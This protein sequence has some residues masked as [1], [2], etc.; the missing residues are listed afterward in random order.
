MRKERSLAVTIFRLVSVLPAQL[1][2]VYLTVVS[3]ISLVYP[4]P[5]SI[6]WLSHR[7]FKTV[8]MIWKLDR[9]LPIRTLFT[10]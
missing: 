4:L 7:I 6:A 9:S 3:I 10:S 1:L 5:D 2:C 8:A